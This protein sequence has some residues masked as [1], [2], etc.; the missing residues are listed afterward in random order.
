MDMVTFCPL[1]Q[2]RGT[3]LIDE[4]AMLE[5]LNLL[6]ILFFATTLAFAS[7]LNTPD[8]RNNNQ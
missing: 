5:C 1:I 3:R 8:D 7:T 4:V 2:G 6:L